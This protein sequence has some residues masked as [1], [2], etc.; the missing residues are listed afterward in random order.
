MDSSDPADQHRQERWPV[1]PSVAF[2]EVDPAGF[3]ERIEHPGVIHRDVDQASGARPLRSCRCCVFGHGADE[4]L[5]T[6]ASSC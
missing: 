1:F 5:R 2:S 3:A 4:I 6:A